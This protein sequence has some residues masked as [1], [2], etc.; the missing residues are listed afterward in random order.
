MDD[1]INLN[2]LRLFAKVVE[3]GGF[4]AAGRA[5]G[6]PK[7]T[8]SKRVAVLE[9]RLGARL[10]QRNARRLA[11]TE[12]GATIA[13]HAQTM[14]LSAEV[15]EAAVAERLAEPNGTVRLTCSTITARYYLAPLWPEFA[16]LYPKV[17]LI[18]NCSDRMVDLIGKGF[19]LALRDHVAPLENT[20]LIAQHLGSEPD[21]LVASS[22]W[23]RANRPI[24]SPDDIEASD[25]LYC[26]STARAANWPLVNQGGERAVIRLP[27]RF[28]SDDPG[29]VVA[30][31]M[32]GLGIA[33]LPRCICA[34]LIGSGDL[35]RVLPD[36]TS[37][38]PT[39]SLLYPH[40]RGQLPATR[41]TVS[42]LAERLSGL[43]DR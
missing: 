42:F 16:S 20:D 33:R 10:L 37:P 34:P 39:T 30:M 7:S 8:L 24:R 26:S 27:L 22:G 12:L 1:R 28:G 36:W 29:S 23:V 41:A 13:E 4:A 32:A 19:D 15:V 43:L 14:L 17:A 6:L 18:V 25:G 11:T 5:V 35:V 31:A 9:E 2:D 40:R 3:H 38:G 21:Y